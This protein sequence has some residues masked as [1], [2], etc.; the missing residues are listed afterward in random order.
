MYRKRFLLDTVPLALASQAF[1]Q[2]LFMIHTIEA[3]YNFT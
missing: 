2:V 1:W 3:N